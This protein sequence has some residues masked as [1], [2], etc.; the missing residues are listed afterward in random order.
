LDYGL[1]VVRTLRPRWVVVRSPASLRPSSAGERELSSV[2]ERVRP[3]LGDSGLAWEPRGLWQPDQVAR[4][5]EKCGALPVSD[6]R[7]LLPGDLAYVRLLHVG[8]GTRT[9]GRAIEQLALGLLQTSE[10]YLVIDGGPAVPVKRQLLA[11]FEEAGLSTDDDELDAE[12]QDD[13]EELD[14][15]EEQDDAEELDDELDTE[16]ADVDDDAPD[17]TERMEPGGQK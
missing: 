9:S 14:D 4:F 12:E 15:A 1:Q 8:T 5:A 7:E 2:L 10:A 16:D 11:I 13:A 17:S 3:E 6:A